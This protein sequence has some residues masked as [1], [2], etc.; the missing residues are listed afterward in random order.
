MTRFR[1]ERRPAWNILLALVALV[2]I[3]ARAINIID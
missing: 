2:L 1:A 3:A